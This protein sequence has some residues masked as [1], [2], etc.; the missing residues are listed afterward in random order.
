[1]QKAD[2]N[3]DRHG[4]KGLQVLVTRPAEQ[5]VSLLTAIESR[6]G[7]AHSFPLLEIQPIVPCVP[8]LKQL[9]EYSLVIFVSRNAVEYSWPCLSIPLPAALKVAAVGQATATCLH[10]YHQHVDIIP[11]EQFDSEGLLAQPELADVA[12]QR[13]LII[14]G[15]GGREKLAETLR[16]RGA[17]VDYAEVYKRL[18]TKQVLTYE[19]GDIDVILITSSEALSHLA[20]LATQA[21]KS[22]LLEKPL[23]VLHDRIAVRAKQLGF[24]LNPGV[25]KQASEASLLEAL[26]LFK[27]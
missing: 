11:A 24:K 5:S 2:P 17:I 18:P 20:H 13:I 25:A 21:G 6:G 15:Q 4:L 19:A 8:E 1:M 10:Q 26:H 12:R 23:L 7:I 16:A 14:R 3:S 22:W 27:D 9:D